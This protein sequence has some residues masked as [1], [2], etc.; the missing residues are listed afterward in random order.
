[1]VKITCR[2]R[3][4]YMIVFLTFFTLKF[5]ANWS[6]FLFQVPPDVWLPMHKSSA[7][8]WRRKLRSCPRWGDIY[9]R[10]IKVGQSFLYLHQVGLIVYPMST[11]TCTSSAKL[12]VTLI[13]A[14]KFLLLRASHI[15]HSRHTS[16]LRFENAIFDR[17]TSVRV[18]IA[19][20]EFLRVLWLR[21]TVIWAPAVSQKIDRQVLKSVKNKNWTKLWCLVKIPGHWKRIQRNYNTMGTNTAH[22]PP[23]L[24]VHSITWYLLQCPWIPFL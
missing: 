2:K 20:K 15:L 12:S 19:V 1:M 8:D 22:C 3:L 11:C 9:S 23:Q 5:I 14:W 16:C 7:N 6:M 18:L 4:K 17:L 21:T 24:H 10:K 13:F